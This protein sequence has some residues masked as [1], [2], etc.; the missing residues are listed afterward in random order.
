MLILQQIPSSGL[1][2][3][4]SNEFGEWME[5]WNKFIY[6]SLNKFGLLIISF[7]SSFIV[8]WLIPR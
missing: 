3:M 6:L 4:W 1:E 2:E 8:P 5:R 7:V